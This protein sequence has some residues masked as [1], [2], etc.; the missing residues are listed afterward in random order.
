MTIAVGVWALFLN[1]FRVGVPT[2][3]WDE[4]IY[5]T[6]GWRYVNA[7]VFAP[8]KGGSLGDF[9]DNFE[10]PPFAKY[11]FGIGELVAGQQSVTATRTVAALASL[12]TAALL[13]WWLARRYDRWTGLAAGAVVALAPFVVAPSVV[14]FGRLGM[15]DPVAGLFVVLTL[16]LAWRWWTARPAE[17]MRWAAVT[18]LACGLATSAKESSFLVLVGPV[19]LG[20][21]TSWRPARLLVQRTIETLVLVATTAAVFVATYL[22]VGFPL[23]RIRYLWDFQT[24][25]SR[26]GHVVVINGES[27]THAPWWANLWFTWQGLGAL[28]TVLMTVGALLALTLGRGRVVAFLSAAMVGP[29]VFFFFLARVALPFYW[30]MWIP[31]PVAI[32]VVGWRAAIQAAGRRLPHRSLLVPALA[33][34]LAV[35]TALPSVANTVTVARLTVVGVGRV[36]QLMRAERLHGPIVT[37]GVSAF[38]ARTYLGSYQ[39]VTTPAQPGQADTIVIGDPVCGRPKDR[40]AAALV[41]LNRTRGTIRAIYADPQVVVY[42]ASRPLVPPGYLDVAAIKPPSC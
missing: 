35:T 20:L 32:A 37:T 21:A 17:A 27:T 29:V 5:A 19:L 24:R 23:D 41:A 11:L 18:G 13:G 7:E 38:D 28:L 2:T 6:A 12:A 3:L 10:H 26:L 40:V 16:V 4:P 9:A 1:L 30:V 42:A 25:H 34:A 39:L 14:R 8:G 22:P 15:L 36:P 31:I 33:G